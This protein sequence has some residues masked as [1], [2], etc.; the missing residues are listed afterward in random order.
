MGRRNSSSKK[1]GRKTAAGN[2]AFLDEVESWRGILARNLARTTP[3]FSSRDLAFAVERIIERL[4]FLR[5]CEDR[6]AGPRRGASLGDMESTSA[7]DV[8]H[9][10]AIDGQTLGEIRDRLRRFPSIPVEI[11][12]QIYEQFLSTLKIR[13]GGGVYYTPGE[14]VQHVVENTVGK[15]LEGQFRPGADASHRAAGP[16]TPQEASRLRILDPACGAG[17]FLVVVYQYLLDWHRDWYTAHGAEQHAQDRNP[18]VFRGPGGQWQLTCAERKRILLDNIFGVDIDP[19]AVEVTRLS[20]LLK[21][22]EGGPGERAASLLPCL[23]DRGA[24]DLTG[25]LKCGNSI[26]GPDLSAGEEERRRIGVFDWQMEFPAVLERGGFDAVVGNP[27][28]GQKDIRL[29]EAGR[30]YLRETY[31]SL[32]GILDLFRPFV[33]KGVQLLRNGGAFGMVLPDIVLLK[34][35]AQTRRFMLENLALT[36]IRWWGM[37]FRDAVIDA[38]TVLGTKH[39]AGADHLVHVRVDDSKEPL[40]HWIPQSDFLANPRYTFNLHL[41]PERRA[42]LASVDALPR[43]GD[44][45]EIHEGIHSGNMRAELFV[46]SA[47]DD[48]CKPMY[49]GRDEIAPYRLQW[50]GRYVRLAAASKTRSAQK[51]ANVGRPSWHERPKVLVRRTGDRVTAAVDPDSLYASNN[52]FLLF[53]KSDCSLDLFGLCALL[54]S[55]FVTWYFRTIEPRKGRV[56][57]E[58]KIKHIRTFPLP[59]AVAQP[60]SC[61]E[62]NALGERYAAEAERL[63]AASSPLARESCSDILR[64]LEEA[65]EQCVASSLG[66]GR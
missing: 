61:A 22:L 39:P 44:Y 17:S 45:F 2:T 12:G 60:E 6:G 55:R 59:A 25:N 30:R 28:W 36:D 58:L 5:I 32:G 47:R 43:I 3:G 8:P 24:L 34:D 13:K 56:F 48:S 46:D 52:F 18:P 7:R 33:E 38:V 37:A 63:A 64:E 10:A 57:S 1:V 19:Q 14:V 29:D 9:W 16:M 15:L 49:F 35:Y 65:V 23:H 11:L 54:N 26:I 62:L 20:L 42:V 51:Y 4:V 27:P 40:D 41:T 66:L 53:P 50:K 21:M 31:R